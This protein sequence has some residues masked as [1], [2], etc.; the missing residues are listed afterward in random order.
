MYGSEQKTEKL[1]CLHDVAYLPY[2]GNGNG[3]MLAC[4][5]LPWP[6]FPCSPPAMTQPGLMA[7]VTAASSLS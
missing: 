1:P 4:V 5:S 6:A 3:G 7:L 2:T